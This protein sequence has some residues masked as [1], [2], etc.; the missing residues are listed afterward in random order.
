MRYV[1]ASRDEGPSPP[2]IEYCTEMFCASIIAAT[3]WLWSSFTSA[4]IAPVVA[5]PVVAALVAVNR[6]MTGWMKCLSGWMTGRM[7]GGRIPGKLHLTSRRLVIYVI[8]HPIFAIL[9]IKF[10]V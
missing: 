2:Y 4:A 6:W 8:K 10:V 7:M 9:K 5:I 3:T 1:S